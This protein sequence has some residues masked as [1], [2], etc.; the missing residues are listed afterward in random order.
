M[1]RQ[2]LSKALQLYMAEYG[3]NYP[4]TIG[5]QGGYRGGASSCG[6]Q[7]WGQQLWYRGGA[8]SCGTGVG[9][10]AVVQG[11]GQQ[12]WFRGGASSCGTGVLWYR[13]GG[14]NCGTEVASCNIFLWRGLYINFYSPGKNLSLNEK[15][16]MILFLVR[17][18][19][20]MSKSL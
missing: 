19:H 14:S 17:S 7:G 8:S 15:K 13:G 4:W 2:E 16:N 18:R 1:R 3:P 10:A 9:L 6:N 5:K 20:C 12:L 11:W